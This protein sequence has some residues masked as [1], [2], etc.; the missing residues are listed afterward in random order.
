L[1][2]RLF[3]IEPRPFHAFDRGLPA[4]LAAGARPFFLFAAA[5]S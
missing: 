4:A 2:P 3:L 1:A 5:V